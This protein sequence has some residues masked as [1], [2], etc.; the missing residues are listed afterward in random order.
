[1]FDGTNGAYFVAACAEH[2]AIIWVFH[3]WSFLA[4]FLFKFECSKGAVF[5]AFSAA[6]AFFIVY[7][8]VPRYF[9]SG[10][11]VPSFFWHF[12]EPLFVICSVVLSWQLF[13][14]IVNLSVFL[15]YSEWIVCFCG[16]YGFG[17]LD[18]ISMR[19]H[20]HL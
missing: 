13:N 8:G 11:S 18:R 1:V 14:I 6:Y 16:R 19:R 10:N 17:W 4:V 2:D 3:N 9:A 5:D 7:G 20:L 15:T 12:H